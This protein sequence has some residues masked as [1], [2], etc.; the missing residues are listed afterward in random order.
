ML[1]YYVR[2]N[3][4]QSSHLI[5]STCTLLHITSN[6]FPFDIVIDPFKGL[7]VSEMAKAGI[8]FKRAD[9]LYKIEPERTD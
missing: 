8:V 5:I 3:P 6:T 4:A 1:I 2:S 7:L 9:K